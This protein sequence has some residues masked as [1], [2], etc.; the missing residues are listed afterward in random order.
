MNHRVVVGCRL[1][2]L[3][4]IWS[5]IWP[6]L[7]PIPLN[8]DATDSGKKQRETMK[9]VVICKLNAGCHRDEISAAYFECSSQRVHGS[10]AVWIF[11]SFVRSFICLLAGWCKLCVA[12][13]L[14]NL[15]II[16]N[17]DER[18]RHRRIESNDILLYWHF[19]V[20]LIDSK[21]FI[22][23]LF[24]R[25]FLPGIKLEICD[26]NTNLPIY[27]INGA[28]HAFRGHFSKKPL[29]FKV[30]KSSSSWLFSAALA[31]MLAY[32]L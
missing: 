32:I 28:W 31:F 18:S 11:R 6:C 27:K 3:L 21:N 12:A 19:T 13:E 20:F 17:G 9:R 26:I 4:L 14:I 5:Q 15:V 2:L 22:C 1:L 30:S 29:E 8:S 23:V 16:S 24:G 25:S 7:P 10:G